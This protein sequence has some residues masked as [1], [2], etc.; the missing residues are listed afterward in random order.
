MSELLIR[1]LDENDRPWVQ[2]LLTTHW[3]TCTIVTRERMHQADEL[4][5]FIAE[6]DGER[7]GLITY[8]IED[9]QCEMISLNSLRE[10][11]GVGTA[12]LAAAQ[13]AARQAG[14]QRV[15]L[16]TSNDNL[17][18]VRF[19]Q[20]RGWRL[21]AIHRGALDDARRLKPEIPLTGIDGIPLHD[22]IEMEVPA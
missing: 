6:L 19:Y 13:T 21:V 22:E 9:E 11:C 1:Q 14:C 5:G 12:L 3:G 18:A 2:H 17:P 10:G 4:P 15:W 16:I 8:R 7:C 20:R